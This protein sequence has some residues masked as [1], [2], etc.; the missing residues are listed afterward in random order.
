MYRQ[1]TA[2]VVLEDFFS[3]LV[4]FN[5]IVPISLYVTLEVQK[6]CGSMFLA[7]DRELYCQQSDESAR[8]NSSDLNEELGQIEIL[9]SDKGQKQILIF[10]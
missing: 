7:W 9:F 8:C 6:F 3:F 10:M 4:I 5:N 2:L 1:V